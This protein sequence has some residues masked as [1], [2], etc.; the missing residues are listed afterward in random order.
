[1]LKIGG[2][3]LSL[4]GAKMTSAIPFQHQLERH[5][6]LLLPH[7]LSV[8]FVV[9]SY[10]ISQIKLSGGRICAFKSLIVPKKSGFGAT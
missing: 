3:L 8:S 4:V 10:V 9:V 7:E 1:V 5:C 6:H 2:K